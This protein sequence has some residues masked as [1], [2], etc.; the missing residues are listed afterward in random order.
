MLLCR[1]PLR[2]RDIHG[3]LVEVGRDQ[4]TE[5]RNDGIDQNSRNGDAVGPRK[6]E[7]TDAPVSRQPKLMYSL[8]P[9]ESL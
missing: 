1:L 9:A 2:A 5:S 7:M 3:G 8:T 6:S 4:L